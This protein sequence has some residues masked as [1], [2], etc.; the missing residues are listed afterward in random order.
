ME[1]TF[2][3]NLRQCHEKKDLESSVPHK[4]NIK[5]LEIYRNAVSYL[6]KFA[7]L[8][9]TGYDVLYMPPLLRNI[10]KHHN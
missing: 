6:Q 1:E 10:I 4:N 2:D 9:L 7:M 8:S 5:S 3:Y